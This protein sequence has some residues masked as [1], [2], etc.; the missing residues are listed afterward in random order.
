MVGYFEHKFQ[1]N[2]GSPTNDCWRQ[3]TRLSVLS[4]GIDCIII[5]LAIL[6]QYQLGTDGQTNKRTDRHMM[7]ANTCASIVSHG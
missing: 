6:V 5:R 3:E 7:M 2:G 4:R 1:G